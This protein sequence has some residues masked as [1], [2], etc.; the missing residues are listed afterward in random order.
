[1]DT[2]GHVN[3]WNECMSCLIGYNTE[4]AMEWLLVHNCTTDNFKTVVQI[5]LDQAQAGNETNNF[6]FPLITKSSYG[7]E[8]L[9]NVMS[10]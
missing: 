2:F 5:V 9:L 8:M 4:E 7:I 10:C 3:V 1:V 6:E